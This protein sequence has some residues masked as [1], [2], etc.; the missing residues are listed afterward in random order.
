M[1]GSIAFN[2]NRACLLIVMIAQVAI[3]LSLSS[4]ASSAVLA[5][6][7]APRNLAATEIADAATTD[8]ECSEPGTCS[9]D[10]GSTRGWWE[11]WSGG[12]KSTSQAN[13]ASSGSKSTIPQTMDPKEERLITPEEL[14]LHTGKDG[15][16]IWLSILGKVFDV[17][18]GEDFYGEGNGSYKFYAGRD[19]SP[20]FS[21]GKNTPEGAA[22][23]LEEWDDDQLVAVWEWSKF[24]EDHETY[25]YLG[26]LAGGRYFD[27]SGNEMPLRQD[28]M[29]RSSEAKRVSDE[30]R[31]R[32][33]KERMAA[34]KKRKK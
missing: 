12:S 3:S 17:S 31:A 6:S 26:I 30:I 32:K 20:C 27:E 21:S 7:L 33:K 9:V 23:K 28:I 34:R 4:R 14:A 25:K 1:A 10:G 15:G 18:T 22:E 16:P 8:Q 11:W 2:S 29:R 24:Y 5:L 19:A 13:S